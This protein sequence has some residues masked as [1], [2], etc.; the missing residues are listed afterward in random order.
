[1]QAI[2]DEFVRRTRFDPFHDAD[3][4]QALYDRLPTLLDELKQAEDTEVA[5]ATPTTPTASG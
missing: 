1:M 5:M 2:A 3:T 4:E